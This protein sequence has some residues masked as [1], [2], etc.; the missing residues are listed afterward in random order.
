V[1]DEKEKRKKEKK[2]LQFITESKTLIEIEE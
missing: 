1:I 2:K